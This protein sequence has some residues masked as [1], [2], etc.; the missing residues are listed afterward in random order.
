MGKGI[1]ADRVR[2]KKAYEAPAPENGTPVLID[3]LCDVA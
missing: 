2:L 3:L 1:S